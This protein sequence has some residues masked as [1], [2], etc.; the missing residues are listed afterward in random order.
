MRAESSPGVRR[1]RLCRRAQGGER[2]RGGDLSGSA[3]GIPEIDVHMGRKD[4]MAA[5][6]AVAH[7]IDLMGDVG[8]LDAGPM[9]GLGE[10]GAVLSDGRALILGQ[11]PVDE[12]T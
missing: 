12:M 9:D 5:F 6:Q 8:F 2:P 11:G 10:A 1:A 7:A 3:E 4:V